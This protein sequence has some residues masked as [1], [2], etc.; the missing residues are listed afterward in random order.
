MRFK[1]RPK[2]KSEQKVLNLH[3]Q[4]H[5]VFLIAKGFTNETLK[6][7]TCQHMHSLFFS[8][9]TNSKEDLVDVPEEAVQVSMCV[10]HRKT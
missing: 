5:G 6:F 9:G 4:Q 10:A 8:S 3:V 2:V 1:E 7:I